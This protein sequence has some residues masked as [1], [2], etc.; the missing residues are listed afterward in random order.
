MIP[1]PA[2]LSGSWGIFWD[3]RR[4]IREDIFV[5]VRQSSAGKGGEGEGRRREQIAAY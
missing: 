2:N 4:F 3:A 5:F 1:P